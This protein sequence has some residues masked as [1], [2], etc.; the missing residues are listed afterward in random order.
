MV[1]LLTCGHAGATDGVRSTVQGSGTRCGRRGHQ[2]A[3]ASFALD[4]PSCIPYWHHPDY[5]LHSDL[6]EG[7]KLRHRGQIPVPLC[8]EA[9]PTHLP[10]ILYTHT[11]HPPNNPPFQ[12]LPVK[13]FN[14]TASQNTFKFHPK[15]Y[16]FFF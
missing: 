12:Q 2:A 8:H 13:P 14:M 16:F 9:P 1:F 5:M 4:R 6:H 11:K 10:F 7:R 3:G 15:W